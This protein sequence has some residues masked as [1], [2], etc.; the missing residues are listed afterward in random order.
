MTW[1]GVVWMVSIVIAATCFV[2][3]RGFQASMVFTVVFALS[4]GVAAFL[5]LYGLANLLFPS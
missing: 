3:V 1:E 4:L 5:T 2:L